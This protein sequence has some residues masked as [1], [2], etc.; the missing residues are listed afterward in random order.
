MITGLVD[1]VRIGST[2]GTVINSGTIAGTSPIYAIGNGDGIFITASGAL[3]TNSFGGRVIGVN[4]GVEIAAATATVRNFG[5]IA[6]TGS[7]GTAVFLRS[8]G[9]YVGNSSIGVITGYFDG[10]LIGSAAGTV[11]NSG[12]IK[13]TSTIIQGISH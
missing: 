3:V 5:A 2:A 11:V 10:V 12:T 13:S 8:G 1:G 9:G 4:N 7:L 6:A